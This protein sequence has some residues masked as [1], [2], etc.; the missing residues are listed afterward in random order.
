MNGDLGTGCI[1]RITKSLAN[2]KPWMFNSNIRHFQSSIFVSRSRWQ[3]QTVSSDP[4]DFGSVRAFISTLKYHLT[5]YIKHYKKLLSV[6]STTWTMQ[7]YT[8][9]VN[10]SIWFLSAV[11]T[12]MVLLCVDRW[13]TSQHMQ[14]WWSLQLF[15]NT[16][17]KA[18]N[19]K[20]E[21]L[22]RYSVPPQKKNWWVLKMRKPSPCRGAF[23]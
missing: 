12:S 17:V 14:P 4:M 15:L 19:I 3:G 7:L 23:C 8:K 10:Q 21:Y 6:K 11:K 1:R 22:H 13:M 16:K 2:V 20:Y 5:V 9:R 18:S